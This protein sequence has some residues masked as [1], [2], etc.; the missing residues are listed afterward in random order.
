MSRNK[1][2]P[3]QTKQKEVITMLKKVFELLLTNINIYNLRVDNYNKFLVANDQAVKKDNQRK[4][5]LMNRMDIQYK[6]LIGLAQMYKATTNNEIVYI[7]DNIDY[8]SR[9]IAVSHY[10]F[11]EDVEF[12][13]KHYTLEDMKNYKD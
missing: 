7:H 10:D 11:K 9:I 6:K 8:Y 4:D 5:Y 13:N 1:P 12:I 3:N 2:N